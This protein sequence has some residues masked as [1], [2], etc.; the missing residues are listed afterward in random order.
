MQ[1][2][3]LFRTLLILHFAKGSVRPFRTA[4]LRLAMTYLCALV[5]GYLLS[6]TM[7]QLTLPTDIPLR[8]VLG[9]VTGL[10]FVLGGL[11]MLTTQANQN[12]ATKS[13]IF[14]RQL[15]LL[16]ISPV[17]RWLLQIVPNLL[18][19]GAIAVFGSMLITP[20]SHAL[21]QP[22]FALLA[23]W[24]AGLV[25]SYGF[26]LLPKPQHLVNKGVVFVAVIALAF[27]LLDWMF[28]STGLFAV[29]VG[30]YVLL[31]MLAMPI[32]G[33]YD[34]YRH[35]YALRPSWQ[36]SNFAALMPKFIPT[37]AWFVVKLW[38]NVRSRNALLL[39]ISL[40]ALTAASIVIRH[41]VFTD[42]YPVLLFGAILAA[43]FACEVRGLMRRH[44]PPEA[45]L[46]TGLRGLVWSQLGVVIV[47]G[48]VIG[49]PVFFALNHQAVN[50]FQFL[51]F[52]CYLQAFA[53]CAGLLAS[54]LFVPG[55]GE[56]GAQF[57]AAI[58]ATSLLLGFPKIA[59]LSDVPYGRQMPYWIFSAVVL[60]G[61]VF[62]IENIRRKNYGRT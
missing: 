27:R 11:L 34:Q 45:P 18:V 31:I 43:T 52:Y 4:I 16:P 3:K 25:S 14:Q 13:A 54:T 53:S 21:Q 10:G 37:K 56:S 28:T 42:P 35:G 5:F 59:K 2:T 23:A 7:S 58:L 33:L 32:A 46:L 19:V 6:R 22:T 38:R 47:V 29:Q 51:I 57:F 48:F 40:S 55:N 41:K 30:P 50:S 20:I 62:V 44:L 8:V 12:G 26:V 9:M 24:I 15:R 61:G 60:T 39:A 1:H 49:L 36:A 17:I